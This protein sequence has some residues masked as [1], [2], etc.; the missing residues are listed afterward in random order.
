LWLHNKLGAQE[1]LW[2]PSSIATLLTATVMDNIRL[3]FHR[4]SSAVKLKLRLQTLCRPNCTA[5]EMKD[6]LMEI[7]QLATLHSYP[8]VLMV[9]DILKS[10]PDKRSLNLDLEEQ[11]PNIQDTLGE[12]RGKV[13]EC[14]ALPCC[15]WNAWIKNLL[16]ML[17]GPLTLPV[18]H[19]QLKQKPKS[20]TLQEERLQKSTETAQQ[21]K[22]SA[23]LV[24]LLL[25]NLRGPALWLP[26][27]GCT[28]QLYASLA[29]DSTECV[30]L[31]VMALDPGTA[32]DHF[33][34]ER[35]ALLKLACGGGRNA[36]ERQM[37]TA[38]VVNLLVLSSVILAA[39]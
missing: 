24:S 17:A 31:A 22:R 11:N 39:S 21:L 26:R 3:C 7:V 9:A 27:G 32:L 29:L 16:T 18:K 1:E 23:E 14:E 20:A 34:C 28:P 4:L 13:G 8:W 2:A 12:L 30:L 38:P 25:T 5:D 19:F 10:F 15:P 33:I 37:F 6:G 36:I 35:P